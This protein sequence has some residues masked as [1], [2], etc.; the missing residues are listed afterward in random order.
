MKCKKCEFEITD[1]NVNVCPN[2]GEKIKKDSFP[3]WVIPV[4]VVSIIVFY[5]ALF[6]LGFW[7]AWLTIGSENKFKDTYV[8]LSQMKHSE[9]LYNASE[10]TLKNGA[11]VK[12]EKLR[13]CTTSIPKETVNYTKDTACSILTVDINGFKK[14]P[15]FDTDGTEF[16]DIYDQYTLLLYK[17]GIVPAYGSPEF[18]LLKNTLIPVS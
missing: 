7:L 2:C 8:L 10:L 11:E 9:T 3:V 1:K 13:E 5:I 18:E 12:F 16:G 14:G 15:N 17:D 4:I 6:A